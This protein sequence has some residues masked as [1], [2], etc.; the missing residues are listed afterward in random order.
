MHGG[1]TNAD[2]ILDRLIHQYHRIELAG[3]SMR[4]KRK[5]INQENHENIYQ[6]NPV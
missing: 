3:E 6:K 5:K 1:T 2:A 4:R